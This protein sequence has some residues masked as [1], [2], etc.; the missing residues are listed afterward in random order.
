MK[1]QE[2]QKNTNWTWSYKY[3]IQNIILQVFAYDNVNSFVIF[4]C[5]RVCSVS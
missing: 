1:N 2:N 5:E 3:M 4:H